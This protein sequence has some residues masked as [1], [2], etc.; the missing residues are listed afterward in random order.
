MAFFI[1][2]HLVTLKPGNLVK[3]SLKNFTRAL[4]GTGLLLASVNSLAEPRNVGSL[5]ATVAGQVVVF[6]AIYSDVDT[7]HSALWMV[8]DGEQRMAMLGGY[9]SPD[10]E[11]SD[12]KVSGE[13]AMLVISFGYLAGQEKASYRIPSA[14][15]AP[16][17]ILL[18]SRVGDYTSS[19]M[20][21]QGQL[22]VT[23]IQQLAD[24]TTRF[25]GTFNGTLEDPDG[26]G[27]GTMI[28]EGRFEL[29]ARQLAPR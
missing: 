2:T 11:F 29:E 3:I 1:Y 9:E 24:G 16:V 25:E 13:G 19:R 8:Q 27:A 17:N 12:S 18:M 10:V 23:Q 4:L 20:V 26:T 22:E 7:N 28:A 5:E 15:G 21:E 14:D 6:H